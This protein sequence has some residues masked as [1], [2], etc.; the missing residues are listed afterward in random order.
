MK[1]GHDQISEIRYELAIKRKTRLLNSAIDFCNEFI[2]VSDPDE[3]QKDFKGYV[4]KK[5][6]D[7]TGIKNI[8]PDKLVTLTDI[9]IHQLNKLQKEYKSIPVD[10]KEKKPDFGIY[11]EGKDQ[12]ALF[13]E[14]TELCDQLNKWNPENWMWIERSFQNKVQLRSGHWTPSTTYIKNHCKKQ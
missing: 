4:M 13:N 9:P 8:D 3:F 12:L 14:L 11:I 6:E 2:N 1:I 7:K 5:I 10:L